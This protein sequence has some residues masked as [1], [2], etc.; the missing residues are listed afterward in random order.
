MQG[1][2]VPQGREWTYSGGKRWKG[3]FC[4]FCDFK[5][6][7]H[8]NVSILFVYENEQ[9]FRRHCF[10]NGL[11]RLAKLTNVSIFDSFSQV[12]KGSWCA[13]NLQPP[14]ER[15]HFTFQVVFKVSPFL[16]HDATW[17]IN[18][19]N[20]LRILFL[21]S[22]CSYL[23]PQTRLHLWSLGEHWSTHTSSPPLPTP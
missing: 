18:V 23:K 13:G 15:S 22:P 16:S 17:E 3:D 10:S 14:L 9:Q 19:G 1:S 5:M 2:L 20:I 21:P 12:E 4:K 11:T 8:V 6:F 7:H